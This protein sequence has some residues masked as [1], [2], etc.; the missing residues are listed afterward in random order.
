MIASPTTAIA[1]SESIRDYLRIRLGASELEYLQPPF[2]MTEGY[3][4][5]I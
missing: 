4:A 5:Y 1:V 2:S 3:A